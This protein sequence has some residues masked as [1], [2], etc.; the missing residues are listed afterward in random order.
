MADNIKIRAQEKG[1]IVEIK[2]LMGHVMETGT[3]KDTKT[4]EL[5]PAHYIQEVTAEANGKT[6]LKANW[7]PAVSTNPYLAFKFKGAAKGDKL[8]ISW[9]DN[10]GATAS[11][12]VDIT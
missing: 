8:K 10:K 5:I 9:V 2:V 1:G 4:G 3:R 12:E 6:V 7:G 11:E